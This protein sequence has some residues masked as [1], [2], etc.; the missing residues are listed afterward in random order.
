M[1]KVQDKAEEDIKDIV[2]A[3]DINIVETLNSEGTENPAGTDKETYISIDE[4]Q[5]EEACEVMKPV[6]NPK[7]VISAVLFSVGNSVEYKKLAAVL[8]RDIDE[9]KELV[10]QLKKEYDSD[11]DCGFTVIELEESVQM[12]SKASMYEHLIKIAKVPKSYSLTDSML[13]TLSIIAYKQPVTKLEIEKIRGVSCDRAVNKLVEYG[14]VTELGRLQAPGR[15]LLFG[16]TEEFLRSFNVTSL[17]DLPTASP[18]RI[19]EFKKEAAEEV[20]LKLD[21]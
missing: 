12:C 19:E 18:D 13:E 7:A 1:S 9:T 17:D 14:L 6:K 2:T 20:S 21:I 5:A 16:T 10:A 11:D 4:E 15:P 3:E 8:G